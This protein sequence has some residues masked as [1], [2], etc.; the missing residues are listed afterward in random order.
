M[1]QKPQQIHDFPNPETALIF[2]ELMESDRDGII[3]KLEEAKAIRRGLMFK[4]TKVRL[5]RL[6]VEEMLSSELGRLNTGIAKAQISRLMQYA[7]YEALEKAVS[8]EGLI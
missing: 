8:E 4:E 6:I 3:R 7:N 5:L 1:T 2:R